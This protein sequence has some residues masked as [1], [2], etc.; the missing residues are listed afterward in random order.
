M[1]SSSDAEIILKLYELRTEAGMRTARQFVMSLP[2]ESFD[3]LAAIQRD[4]GSVHNGYWRQVLSYWEMAAALV[5][6]DALDPDLFLDANNEPFFFYAKFTPFL[7]QWRETFGVPL[8]KLTAKMIE[9]Y[10]QMQE[11]YTMMVARMNAQKKQ[12]GRA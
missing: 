9:T 8:M 11:R 5:L 4:F 7:D 1:A 2:A 3:E 10:P 12:A 6:N